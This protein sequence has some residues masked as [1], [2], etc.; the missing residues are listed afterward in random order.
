M[1]EINK[2]KGCKAFCREIYG[3][4]IRRMI[5]IGIKLNIIRLLSPNSS[6]ANNEFNANS[7]NVNNTNAN[8]QNGSVRPAL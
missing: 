2:Q 6:N 1:P 7:G 3:I 4:N 8:N 5:N